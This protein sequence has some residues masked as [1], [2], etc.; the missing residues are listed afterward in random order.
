MR[1]LQTQEIKAVWEAQPDRFP[2]FL[3]EKRRPLS[4]H[5]TGTEK[6]K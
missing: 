6:R 3:A 4:A 1:Q 5:N 2:D